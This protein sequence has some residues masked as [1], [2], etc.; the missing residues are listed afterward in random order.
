MSSFVSAVTVNWHSSM[1]CREK[2]VIFEGCF[3][4]FAPCHRENKNKNYVTIVGGEVT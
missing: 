1:T 4:N 3:E 2:V